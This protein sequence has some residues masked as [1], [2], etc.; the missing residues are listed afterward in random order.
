[1]ADDNRGRC[2]DGAGHDGFGASRI[3]GGPG[4]HR[5]RGGHVRARRRRGVAV[6]VLDPATDAQVASTTT[7]DDGSFSVSVNSGTYNV[8]LIPPS[9]SGLQSYL[10]TGVATDSAPLTIILKSAVVVQVQGTLQDAQGNVYD[11]GGRT[12]RR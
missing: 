10:A 5:C 9:G 4:Y 1:M 11:S 3:R 6:N 12:H 2:R 7:A 8:Q